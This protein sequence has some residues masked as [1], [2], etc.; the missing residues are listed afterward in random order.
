[1]QFCSFLSCILLSRCWVL[2][3]GCLISQSLPRWWL[4][5][6][7]NDTTFFSL[8]H[9]SC[10]TLLGGY[11]K[12]L[13][14]VISGYPCLILGGDFCTNM[15]CFGYTHDSEITA[16]DMDTL[17]LSKTKHCHLLLSRLVKFLD[18]F[19]PAVVSLLYIPDHIASLHNHSWVLVITI[20]VFAPRIEC[21]FI[22]IICLI[23]HEIACRTYVKPNMGFRILI[24][25]W[26]CYLLNSHFEPSR[27]VCVV[28]PNKLV[29]L[30]MLSRVI[31]FLFY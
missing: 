22:D 13:D 26:Q 19:D 12:A 15:L 5:I 21:D 3:L 14:H 28:L 18:M 2:P 25:R 6:H 11:E 31:V 8:H 27:E 1:M 24:T 10:S 16:F 9:N 20:I 4:S 17:Y 30:P 23:S 7:S 29:V